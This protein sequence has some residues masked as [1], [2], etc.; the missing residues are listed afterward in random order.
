MKG[1]VALLLVTGYV[2]WLGRKR[3]TTWGRYF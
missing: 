2:M 1:L 3:H